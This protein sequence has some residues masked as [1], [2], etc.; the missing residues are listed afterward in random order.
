MIAKS[1]T[2]ETDAIIFDLEDAV[3]IDQK[4]QARKNVCDVL[5]EIRDGNLHVK[6]KIIVRVNAL[7]S[8]FALDDLIQ[9]CIHKPDLIIIPKAEEKAIITVDMILTMLEIQYGL[10]EKQIDIIALVET[11]RGVETV[12]DIISSSMRVKAVQFGAE[13][14]TKDMEIVRT[15]ESDEIQYARNRLAI[16]CKALGIGCIDTPYVDFKNINSCVKDT[17]YV[18]SIGMTGRCVIH[19]SL[20]ELTNC[21]FS[22]SLQEIEEA[23]RIVT[24]YAKAVQEGKGAVA[25]DGKMIDL[26]V[27]Q[28]AKKLLEKAQNI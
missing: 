21:I 28:R 3:N 8:S 6:Q 12:Y 1:V 17:L 13:D 4:E 26:P 2:L 19:P 9:V 11:A 23:D 14:F 22:P 24:A 20:I 15:P 18:K 7:D 25:L 16:A 10:P 27:V 5:K